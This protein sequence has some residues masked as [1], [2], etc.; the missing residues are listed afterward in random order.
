MKRNVVISV[1][2][3][4]CIAV[5]SI[6]LRLSCA[7]QGYDLSGRG[8]YVAL[9]AI[10]AAL[11][12][13]SALL[14]LGVTPLHLAVTLLQLTALALLACV[15][16]GIVSAR[17]TLAAAQFT[18]DATNS[19]GW[20]ALRYTFVCLGGCMAA[21]LLLVLGAF[22]SREKQTEAPRKELPNNI[23]QKEI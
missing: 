10:A 16:A 13:V 15:F 23:H 5:S 17:A 4:V 21:E 20:Q 6:A 14:L 11:V 22:F 8:R 12:A 18:Y 3:I 7:V 19:L 2:T 9:L 1:I